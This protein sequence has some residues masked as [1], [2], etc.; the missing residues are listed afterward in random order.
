[1][2][3]LLA[4]LFA[5]GLSIAGIQPANAS[6]PAYSPLGVPFAWAAGATGKG[7]TVAVIDGGINLN[8]PYFAGKVVDGYCFDSSGG[9]DPYF[10]C[11]GGVRELS[12]ASAGATPASLT[13]IGSVHGN[14]T[15]GIIA[16][17]R[18]VSGLSADSS[19]GELS[20]GPGGIAF[21]ANIF[22][23]RAPLEESFAYFATKAKSLN[24]TAV[25][26]SVGQP[27]PYS[28]NRLGQSNCDAYFPK[29]A[30]NIKAL[31]DMGIPVFVATG[32]QGIEQGANTY[33]ACISSAIPVSAVD[34]NQRV[35]SYANMGTHVRFLAPDNAVSATTTSFK[36]STG[37]SAATPMIAGSYMLMRELYPNA[38]MNQ[39]LDAMGKSI[40][41][42]PDV[43]IKTKGIPNLGSAMTIL[44]ATPSLRSANL[45]TK[46]TAITLVKS[47][48]SVTA[49]ITNPI[50]GMKYELV[51]ASKK[52]AA[53]KVLG[54]KTAGD[55][56]RIT[57]KFA[58]GTNKYAA[59]RLNGSAISKEISWR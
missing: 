45:K 21:E 52:G 14:M 6:D 18:G 24:I 23:S 1:M 15:A 38:S 28:F 8:H 35:A 17:S 27:F 7:Q 12:G 53:L 42:V 39:I 4:L 49:T 40:K 50:A 32:N 16:G 30:A 13:G 34:K 3:K 37:T 57:L 10:A 5:A 55:T 33:P 46:A 47:G 31:T 25:S 36:E 54:S 58:A 41:V 9:Q 26:V 22:M 29:L 59:L 48:T 51:A 43:L 20:S 2:K 56:S 11:P 44:D 19:K